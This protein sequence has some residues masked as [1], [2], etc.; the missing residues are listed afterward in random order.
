MFPEEAQCKLAGWMCAELQD[1]IAR[2]NRGIIEWWELD[3][4]FWRPQHWGSHG[5]ERQVRGS[6]AIATEK[7]T[8]I[9]E[10]GAYQ[11]E[12][13]RDYPEASVD[14]LSRHIEA[15]KEESK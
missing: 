14:V 8:A 2:A 13:I 4:V 7:W 1:G 9:A 12:C 10:A 11:I 6:K 3:S 15:M 5:S